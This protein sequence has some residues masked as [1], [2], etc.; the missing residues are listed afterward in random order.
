MYTLSW[1]EQGWHLRGE[2]TQVEPNAKLAYTW[3]WDHEPEM[4]QRL[5]D[6]QFRPGSDGAEVTITQGPYSE[7]TEDKKDRQDH[8]SGWRYFLGRLQE[9]LEEGVI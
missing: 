3:K 9:R 5:V 4:P 6:L 2:F 1:P 8:L 7:T